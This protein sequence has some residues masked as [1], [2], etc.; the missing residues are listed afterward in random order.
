MSRYKEYLGIILGAL[1]A[2]VIRILGGMEI[3]EDA[4]TIY[5]ITFVWILP[6]FVS[7]I[8]VLVARNEMRNSRMKQFLYPFLSIM[9]FAA[10]A[11]ST[12]LEDLIC[13]FILAIPFIAGAAIFG[14]IV[15]IVLDKI[16]ERKAKKNN[17]LYSLVLLLPLFLNPI[18]SIFSSPEKEYEV[19]KQIRIH[20]SKEKIWSTIIEVPE[21]KSDEYEKGFF[22]YIGVPRPVRSKLE[23]INGVQYR[24][25]YFS[26]ELKLVETISDLDPMKH[27][28]FTIHIDKSQ[29]R[30]LPMDE[31]ILQSDFFTFNTIAYTLIPAANDS[32]LLTLTCSYKIESKM[33]AY[34][35]F[36]AEEVI[37]DFETN[38]LKALKK[39]LE[40]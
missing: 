5:S 3:L 6:L 24:V 18:E 19:K 27:V 7:I 38:L 23:I 31:H 22:N 14:L 40:R 37:G 26:D 36:W 21:I 1:Y 17:N 33:N 39:K 10:I 16:D 4:F 2:M 9:L 12:G 28:A 32:V 35:N 11:L 29:L 25:G 20:A 34:A 30:D 15:G 8:P 13:L